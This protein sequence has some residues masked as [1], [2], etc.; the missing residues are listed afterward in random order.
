M[1]SKEV[2]IL[3]KAGKLE[4]ALSMA[5]QDMQTDPENIWNKRSIAWVYFAFLQLNAIPEKQD[6]FIEYLRKLVFL[7][8]PEDDKMVFDY[9]ASQISKMVFAITREQNIDYSKLNEL[10]ELIKVIPFTQPSESY[11]FLYRAFHK[12]HENWNRYLEFADWWDF[13]NF[14]PEDYLKEE[15]KGKQIMSIVEQAYLAY[16]KN[17]LLKKEVP[18]DFSNENSVNKD[19]IIS[20]LPSLSELIE[21]HPE[22]QYPQ[23]MKAKLLLALGDQENLLAALL[24]FAKAKRNDFWV[25]DVLSEA[26][27]E[28]DERRLSCLCRAVSC[29]ASEDFL[30]KVRQKLA[31]SLI[32]KSL[33]AEAK[34]QI[35]K[36][37]STRNSNEWTIP[38]QIKAWQNQ[39]WYQQ[40]IDNSNSYQFLK[41]RAILADEILFS[42]E[43]EETIVVEFVNLDKKVL[44][45]V[46]EGKRSGYFKFEGKLN[47]PKIGNI[48]EVR[49]KPK[50]DEGFYNLLTVKNLNESPVSLVKKFTGTVKINTEKGFGF[51]EDIFVESWLLKDN[52]IESN[53]PISGEALITYNKKK[54]VWGW[55]AYKINIPAKNEIKNKVLKIC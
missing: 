48:L 5:Q 42:D 28:N 27:P 30:V 39:T 47:N 41:E 36:I 44:N 38:S 9:S 20:F 16:A 32:S 2:T 37:I 46:T 54:E 43:P 8:L 18:E 53:S 7:Q 17:A 35:E 26:F 13:K 25:W 4:E 1:S 11:S 55:K 29:K 50:G 10:F 45:F 15:F 12:G 6:N 31:A 34:V 24:P 52:K 33:N 22:Y 14:R 51:V 19:R 40:N 49:M 21:K 23:Y 3:R